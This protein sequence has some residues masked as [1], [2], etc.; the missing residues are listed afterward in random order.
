[1]ATRAPDG[2]AGQTPRLLHKS[3]STEKQRWPWEQAA[4][5][6]D[7]IRVA[8]LAAE[9]AARIEVAGSV[10][11]HKPHVGDIELL[12]IPLVVEELDPLELLPH[13]VPV[14]L[15]DR[16]IA[17]LEQ[18]GVLGRRKNIKGAEAFGEKNKLMVHLPSGIPVDLFAATQD[19]WYNYLVCRT[20][21]ALSNIA[22]AQ[23]AQARGW[24]WHPYGSGFS[25]VSCDRNYTGAMCHRVGSEADV[26]DFVGLPYRTPQERR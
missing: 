16:A 5:V 6:A 14:N 4:A 9:A 10:R 25:R 2:S 21:G 11:R 22:I 24:K 20:G 23:A 15:A 1:L 12:Y 8:L 17:A 26:F 13:A 3:V 19:N 7:E 18:R